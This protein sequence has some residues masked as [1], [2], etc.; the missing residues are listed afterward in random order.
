MKYICYSDGWTMIPIDVT[1]I[2]CEIRTYY[3]CPH[4]GKMILSVESYPADQEI[5][6]HVDADL[7]VKRL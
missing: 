3:K 6:V 1:I 4:C 7:E 2:E 5:K